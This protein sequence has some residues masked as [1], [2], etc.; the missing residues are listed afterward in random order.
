M[1]KKGRDGVAGVV[2]GEAR[3]FH[4]VEVHIEVGIVDYCSVAGDFLLGSEG[5]SFAAVVDMASL[6]AI[7]IAVLVEVGY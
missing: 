2:H 5:D 4:E 1:G 3:S 6:D 7:E